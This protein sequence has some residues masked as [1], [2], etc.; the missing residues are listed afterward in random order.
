MCRDPGGAATGELSRRMC[1]DPGRAAT[2]KLGQK[3]E[4][5]SRQSSYRGAEQ[6][7]VQ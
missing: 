4:Q 7:D 6:E 5:G 2:V 3:V 1:R